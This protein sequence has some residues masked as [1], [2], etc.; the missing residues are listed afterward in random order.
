LK[1]VLSNVII[2]LLT[3]VSPSRMLTFSNILSS[4][5]LCSVRKVVPELPTTETINLKYDA[6][7][8]TVVNVLFRSMFKSGW[9]PKLFVSVYCH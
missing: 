8:G 6:N 1:M 5:I 9:M 7:T 3:L 2:S 4:T